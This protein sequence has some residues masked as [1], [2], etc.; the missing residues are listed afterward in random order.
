M[1]KKIIFIVPAH[2]EEKNLKE[3]LCSFKKYGDIIVRSKKL[4]WLGYLSTT[5]V[6]GDHKGGWVDENTELKP[7]E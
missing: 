5:G 3:V 2:N 6:Y 4:K 1:K 7:T